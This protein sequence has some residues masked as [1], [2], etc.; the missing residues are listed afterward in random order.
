MTGRS[1]TTGCPL[2]YKTDK[3][4]RPS[5]QPIE[6]IDVEAPP[7]HA[8]ALLNKVNAPVVVCDSNGEIIAFNPACERLSGYRFEDVRN[9]PVWNI[10]SAPADRD[11]AEA[12]FTAAITGALP[13]KQKLVWPTKTG[14]TRPIQWSGEILTNAEGV[15]EYIIATGAD[16]TELLDTRES[17]RESNQCFNTITDNFPVAVY[18]RILNKDG[19]TTTPFSAKCM[20][21]INELGLFDPDKPL[22]LIDY[23]W[24][25]HRERFDIAF[26]KSTKN[27]S[28]LD[29]EF[30]L[31]TPSGRIRWIHNRS[32][33]FKNDSGE[34]VWDGFAVDVTDRR[35]AEEKL[36]AAHAGLEKAI[37]ERT[38]E[39]SQRN[40]EIRRLNEGLEQRV[41]ER[42]EQ[43]RITKAAR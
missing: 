17:L 28:R 12:Y 32:Q 4:R 18:R 3:D 37:E 25:E 33:P 27:L 6:R 2:N 35:E 23:M 16:M 15:V 30:A 21:E 11:A 10:L 8:F 24:P 7:P 38:T 20:R 26:K 34:I 19:V 14:E 39:L 43:L 22:V 41:V 29:F 36:R 5:G 13:D 1:F 40:E 42:T 9:E 31:T